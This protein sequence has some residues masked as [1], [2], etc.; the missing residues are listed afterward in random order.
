MSNRLV[1][2]PEADLQIDQ[3]DDWW[4]ANREKAPRLF[5]EELDRVFRLITSFPNAGRL[6]EEIELAGV[7]RVVLKKCKLHVYYRL[8]GQGVHVLALR[9]AVTDGIPDL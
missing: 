8:L 5:Q 1:V 7:R 3:I 6:Q 9:G 4:R 2:S